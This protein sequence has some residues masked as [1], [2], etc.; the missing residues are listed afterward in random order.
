M[1]LR[2]ARVY[3]EVSTGVGVIQQRR[4]GDV[5]RRTVRAMAQLFN[6][7]RAE[8]RIAGVEFWHSPERCGWLTK[9]G[10]RLR[11][12]RSER[13]SRRR[14]PCHV[15]RLRALT[16]FPF[17]TL[18]EGADSYSYTFAGEYIKTWRRRWFIL[19]QG[20]IFWFK[21]E[22]VGPVS[23]SRT[24]TSFFHFLFLAIC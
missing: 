6:R 24:H 9:Q 15:V 2:Q 12:G 3:R 1:A 8:E 11:Q 21:T 18:K 14:C 13:G 23:H 22:S 4:F 17:E 10:T 19:K 16:S 7:L 5:K 20:K